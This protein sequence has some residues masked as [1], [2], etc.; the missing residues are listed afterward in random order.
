MSAACIDG[1][2]SRDVTGEGED[3]G[4]GYG[5][6]LGSG[7]SEAG[8]DRGSSVDKG[9]GSGEGGGG[10]EGGGEDEG[11]GEAKGKGEGEGEGAGEGAGEGGGV[12]LPPATMT[13][14]AAESQ[15][16]CPLTLCPWLSAVYPSFR[17]KA[18]CD[19]GSI[20][21]ANASAGRRLHAVST[22]ALTATWYAPPTAPIGTRAHPR[23]VCGVRGVESLP[24][25]PGPDCV[26]PH[27]I[28]A[29]VASRRQTGVA[30]STCMAPHTIHSNGTHPPVLT[31]A[32]TSLPA[33]AAVVSPSRQAATCGRTRSIA[34]SER[35]TLRG[36]CPSASLLRLYTPASAP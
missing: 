9:G 1:G 20:K 2:G 14:T 22:F 35:R 13:L 15:L 12:V 10:G 19:C 11:E 36:T 4:F 8:I 7:G 25:T 23:K 32:P 33:A 31:G 28:Q 27:S 18:K 26:S 3:D 16:E 6:G 29:A 5:D 30:A 34:A 17:D 21:G 24:H